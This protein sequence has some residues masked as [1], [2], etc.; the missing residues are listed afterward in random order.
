MANIIF[1]MESGLNESIYGNSQAPIRAF[2]E[3]RAEAY[4]QKSVINTLFNREKSSRFAEKVTSMTSMEGPKPGGENTVFPTDGYQEGFSKTIEHVEWRD[5]FSITRKML[6]DSQLINFKQKPAAFVAAYYRRI[7][8]F[9]AA[10]FGSAFGGSTS[11]THLGQSFDLKTADGVALFSE[12][13]PSKLDSGSTQANVCSDLLTA[14]NLGK[15]ETAHQM[16]KDDNGNILNLAPNRIVIPNT[17]AMKKAAFIAVGSEKDPVTANNAMNYQFGRW[18]ITICPYLNQF[19]D[20]GDSPWMLVD[21]EYNRDFLGAMWFDRVGI[22]IDSYIDRS[23]WANVWQMYF[24][25]GAGFNDWRA[26]SL[27]GVAG[28]SALS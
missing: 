6:D 11:M 19:V 16:F 25:F 24:R 14:D 17:A 2:I 5:S 12:S 7:A 18:D 13:H 3:K 26:F 8:I 15:L 10:M 22:E 27:G 9:G 1:N 28:A 20:A 4:E 21:D 23:T